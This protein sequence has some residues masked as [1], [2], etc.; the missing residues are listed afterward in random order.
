[1]STSVT[2]YAKFLS[3]VIHITCGNSHTRWTVASVAAINNHSTS[4][5]LPP[6][7][8]ISYFICI[9]G[10]FKGYAC[11]RYSSKSASLQARH[12]LEGHEMRNGHILDCQWLKHRQSQSEEPEHYSLHSKCLYID[13]LPADFRDMGQFRKL[14]S[15]VVNPP[16]CQV[17]TM[18]NVK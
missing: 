16:Y 17:R 15:T 13:K 1:M 9:S 12:V 2:L 10:Q 14:F 11:V 18:H 4:K 3:H 8:K 6:I 7:N 5:C